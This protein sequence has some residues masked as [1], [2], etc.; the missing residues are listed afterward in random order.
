[1]NGIVIYS[2]FIISCILFNLLKYHEYYKSTFNKILFIVGNEALKTLLL[3]LCYL[4]HKIDYLDSFFFKMPCFSLK[5]SYKLF[6]KRRYKYAKRVII[7]LM[8]L[9]SL[10]KRML[11]IIVLLSLLIDNKTMR[12]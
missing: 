1:M 3:S 10:P 6:A 9:L 5:F 4:F 12:I 11:I 7:L 2:L 8:E